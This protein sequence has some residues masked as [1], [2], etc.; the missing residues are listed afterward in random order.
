MKNINNV[1]ILSF[2]VQY[3]KS[4]SV[5]K[6]RDELDKI[7][8][9][10]SVNVICLQEN[11]SNVDLKIKGF[12][13]ITECKAEPHSSENKKTHLCN[14]IYI[15]ESIGALILEPLH[16]AKGEYN[17]ERCA[18]AAEVSGFVIVNVHL[19]GGR[20]EDKEFVKLQNKKVEMMNKI[21]SKYQP[22]IIL[23]DFNGEPCSQ[24][25]LE[26]LKSYKLYKKIKGNDIEI[27]WKYYSYVH[28]ILRA[29]G[30]NPAYTKSQ[31]PRTSIYGTTPDWFY[32]NHETVSPKGEPVLYHHLN[33]LS[34]HL[35]I[36][37][38]FR[39]SDYTTEE[40]INMLKARRKK[41]KHEFKNTI[42][43]YKI[44][45]LKYGDT[46][47]INKLNKLGWKKY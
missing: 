32:Y 45:N 26:P 37:M 12:K 31:V 8:L 15:R 34:D 46:I 2:N 41:L 30:Y 14:S 43:K 7:H 22:D 35:P 40:K 20:Y 47:L 10:K 33:K 18:V 28:Y 11:I 23:G 4:A 16:F 29:E 3:F 13:K 6:I 27:F 9:K 5:N 17:V 21:I 25:A 38:N 42:V 44:E 1:G 39:E 24:A 19:C 36:E